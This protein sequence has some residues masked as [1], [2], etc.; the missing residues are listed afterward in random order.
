ML[1][2]AVFVACVLLAPARAQAPVEDSTDAAP[3]DLPVYDQPP[4][5]AEG[6]V[7]TPGYWAWSDDDQDFYWV[8]GTWVLAPQPDFLWT[9]GYWQIADVIFVWHPGYWGRH[10]GFYGGINYGFG[11]RGDASGGRQS[12]LGG[13]GMQARPSAAQ[14]AA[15]NER[16]IE[17]TPAQ[18]QQVQAARA[19]PELRFYQN[20]GRPPVAATS[21]PGVW[22][23]P[24]V[25]SAKSPGTFSVVHEA[26]PARPASGSQGSAVR[27]MTSPEAVHS[28]SPPRVQS[29]AAPPDV[30][31]PAEAPPHPGT[32]AGEHPAPEAPHASPPR[33]PDHPPD[34][35]PEH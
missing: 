6:Y 21:R 20:Q 14:L 11:Y 26:A 30:R 5:P 25:V 23:G 1:L 8:P 19:R 31:R 35:T 32:P 3:P 27:G 24:G 34:R 16:H 29:P 7:W 22:N 13:N 28:D 15:A 10:V 17:A 2:A 33:A 12:Y 9:P 18:R 4:M